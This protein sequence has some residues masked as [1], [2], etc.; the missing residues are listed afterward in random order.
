MP[1]TYQ[2]FEVS[3]C[4][5]VEDCRRGELRSLFDSCR[6]GSPADGRDAA[7]ISVLYAAGLRRAEVVTL[8]VTDYD[9]ESG[10]IT[11]RGKGNKERVTYIDDGAADA[12]GEWLGYGEMHRDRCSAP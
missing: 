3:V 4:H 8:D 7:L 12:K 2:R 10:A 6:G 1:S 11:V 5:E 9:P